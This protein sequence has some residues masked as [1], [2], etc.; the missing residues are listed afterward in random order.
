M[1]GLET[2]YALRKNGIWRRL[3]CAE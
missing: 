3:H 2:M 1:F